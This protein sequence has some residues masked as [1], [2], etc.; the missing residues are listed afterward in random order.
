MQKAYFDI[1][2]FNECIGII[3]PDREVV[4]TGTTIHSMSVTEKDKEYERFAQDYD[5]HFIFEDDIPVL[6]FYTVPAV[7]LLAKDSAG[8]WIGTVFV[9]SDSETAEPVCYIPPDRECFLIAKSI[10]EFVKTADSWKS[11]LKPYH[12]ITFYSSRSDAEQELEFI[13]ISRNKNDGE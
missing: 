8:G 12:Q 5:V 9:Q 13:K 11:H 3:V 1:T 10:E 2:E 7:D 4:F 6:P